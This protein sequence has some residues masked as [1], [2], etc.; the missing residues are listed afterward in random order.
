[1]KPCLAERLVC[2]R[3]GND[4]DI[5]ERVGEYGCLNCDFGGKLH[6]GI[7]LFVEVAG[8]IQPFE[9]KLRGPNYGSPWRQANWRF[10]QEQIRALAH[11][12]VLLDVGAGH[13]DFADIF[14]GREA[15]LLDVYPY[16]EIDVVCNLT[17]T[18]PFRASSF[19]AVVLMNVLEH[20]YDSR[21]LFKV[22]NSL[23]KPGGIFV[24]AVPFLLKV[25]QAPYDFVRYTHF[26][27][28]RLGQDFGF[29]LLSLEGYFDP[30]F[31]MGESWRNIE[32]CELGR[33]SR[34]QR[35]ASR[36]LLWGIKSAA[37][38]LEGWVGKGY[39]QPS[40]QAISPAPIGY[41]AVYRK[42]FHQGEYSSS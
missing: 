6:A 11:D 23:L 18:V 15:I 10:L 33:L 24:V 1:M 22:V 4:L 19:D 2:P 34:I 20:V 28:Q 37:S 35:A 31:L 3:C 9:K 7:P 13:G 29:E 30:I 21:A 17:S 12:A 16:P 38:I 36:G 32:R 42:N 25:H 26:G 39:T 40:E 41:H 5:N 8:D 14:E 27:L